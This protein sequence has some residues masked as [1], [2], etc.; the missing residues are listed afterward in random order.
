LTTPLATNSVTMGTP[1]SAPARGATSGVLVK[2]AEALELM[3]KIDTLV[4]DKTGTLTLGK[5]QLTSVV[6]LTG[7][8]KRTAQ[9]VAR[10]IGGIDKVLA[11][12]LP[13]QKKSIVERLRAEGRRV[14]M[15]GD[16]INDAPGLAAADVG[17][18]MGTGTDVTME[19]AAVTLL[20]GDLGGI[21]RA[22]HLS[23]AVMRNIRQNLFFSLVF[24]RSGRADSRRRTLSEHGIAS[25][26]HHRWGGDGIQLGC[27]YRQL[28]ALAH[29]E[30]MNSPDHFP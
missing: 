9:A 1:W 24:Q 4:V 27:R 13:E 7:D 16:G 5:P 26:P 2:N 21:V 12:V 23:R 30:A 18:A 14:G 20:K 22:R 28:T 8:N 19:S 25:E 6:M 29:G 17:I 3:E 15:A 11:D 10:K